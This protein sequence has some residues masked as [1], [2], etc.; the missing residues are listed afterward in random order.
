M[1]SINSAFKRIMI[2]AVIFALGILVAFA[3]LRVVS[4]NASVTSFTG[5]CTGDAPIVGW[6]GSLWKCIGVASVPHSITTLS[7]NYVSGTGIAGV[8]NTA[9]IV[10]TV[11][12]AANTLTQVGDRVRVRVYWQGTSGSPII[13]ALALNG[14]AIAAQT[15]SGAG[16]FQVSEAWLHYIDATHANIISMNAGTLDLV[17]SGANVAGFNWAGSQ[18]ITLSQNQISNNHII[19]FFMAADIFHK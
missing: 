9:Q 14:V 6:D 12:L 7:T 19:V 1:F 4:P 5:S 17:I 13:G 18:D 10:Q 2:G 8:D 3:I 15:D 11:A 16:K